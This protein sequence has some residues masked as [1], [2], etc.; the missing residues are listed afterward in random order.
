MMIGWVDDLGYKGGTF[1][2]PEMYEDMIYP[3]HVKAT[4][5]AKKYGAFVNMHSHGN[6]NAIVPLL[7]EAG[8]DVLNPVGPMDNM[9]LKTLKE[10]YG[11][12]I[13]FQGGLS[14][15]IGFMSLE[16]LREHLLDRLRVGT[17][18]GGFILSSEGDIPVEMS[19]ENFKAFL[20]MSRKY[21]RNVPNL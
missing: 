20:K 6:I 3:W 16:E 9:D 1:M 10:K 17:P 13:C 4:E 14:R 18:G 21:R 7:V 8:L 2:S 5:L 19:M 15:Y 12:D 11:D